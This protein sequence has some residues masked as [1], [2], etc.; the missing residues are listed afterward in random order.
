MKKFV[1]AAVVAL[2][3]GYLGAQTRP[4][5]TT[6]KGMLV[7]TGCRS[8]QSEHQ[9][10][11]DLSSYPNAYAKTAFGLITAD[12]KCIPLDLSS[13]EKVAGMLKVKTDWSENTA[14]LKPT[15]VEVTGR[16]TGG[17]ISV[18]DIQIK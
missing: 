10:T 13:N 8:S 4:K 1:A 12:G 17:K 16:V 14:K 9:K 6:W 11:G 5:A 15:K 18:D 3:S 7:D 2:V